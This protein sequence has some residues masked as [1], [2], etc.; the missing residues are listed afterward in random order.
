MSSRSSSSYDTCGKLITGASFPTFF[1]NTKSDT[2]WPWVVIILGLNKNT[3][4]YHKCIGTVIG[5][6]TWVITDATCVKG[7][8]ATDIKIF[9]PRIGR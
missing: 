6:N 9:L 3:G 8:K 4:R 2:E 7:L 1:Q 5:D